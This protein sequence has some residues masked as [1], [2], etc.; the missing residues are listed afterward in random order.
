M[1]RDSSGSACRQIRHVRAA[2]RDELRTSP[3]PATSAVTWR[4]GLK[5]VQGDHAKPCLTILL[6][7]TITPP[8]CR[9]RR[10]A[11]APA[12]GIAVRARLDRAGRFWRGGDRRGFRRQRLPCGGLEQSSLPRG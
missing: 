9:P 6:W 1:G 12:L 8:R 7:W 11:D 5:D 4:G 2:G 10:L 3:T